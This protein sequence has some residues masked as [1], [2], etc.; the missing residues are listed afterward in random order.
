MS[1][2]QERL[3]QVPLFSHL[4]R[5]EL[6]KVSE[7]VTEIEVKQGAV[8]GREGHHSSEAFII[9]SG[10]ASIT[11]GGREVAQVGPGELVGELGLLD[12][13]PRAATITASSDM[14][15]Y[16]IEPGAFE[17]LLDESSI[18]KALVRSLAKRLRHADQMI[19]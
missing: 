10:T 17:P 13:G 14:D 3:A 7:V 5:R 11:I 6:D 18:A 2:K 1:T 4:G 19:S 12:G 16:V 8:L 9:V 15:L